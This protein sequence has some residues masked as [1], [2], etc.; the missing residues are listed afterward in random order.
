[1]K[2]EQKAKKAISLDAETGLL[3]IDEQRFALYEKPYTVRKILLTF[4]ESREFIEKVSDVL[5]DITER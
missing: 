2:D 1:M 3:S 5:E 4:Q